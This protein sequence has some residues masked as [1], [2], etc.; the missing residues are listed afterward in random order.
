MRKFWRKN[1]VSAEAVVGSWIFRLREAKDVHE[2]GMAIDE[3]YRQAAVLRVPG[4]VLV[5]GSSWDTLLDALT[6]RAP[7]LRERWLELTG[8]R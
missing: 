5:P 7:D 8:P 4:V 3:I 2:F 1:S 6:A